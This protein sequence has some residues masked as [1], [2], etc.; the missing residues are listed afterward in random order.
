MGL[1][2]DYGLPGGERFFVMRMY[3]LTIYG[4]TV[5]EH[6]QRRGYDS[7]WTIVQEERKRGVEFGC[8]YSEA[9]IDGEL[10]S[11]P[12]AAL[13]E[14]GYADFKRAAEHDWPFLADEGVTTREPVAAVG[15]FRKDGTIDWKWDSLSGDR[16]G[17]LW[18]VDYRVRMTVQA[19][20]PHAAVQAGMEVLT[21]IPGTPAH[22][23]CAQLDVIGLT[24]PR[25]VQKVGT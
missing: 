11:N 8:W 9:C 20:D 19:A 23:A 5:D 3:E 14:I 4:H 1:N 7:D 22:P 2:P 10:G 13:V 12:I 25:F 24:H 18:I 6:L 17:D 21:S 16:T 15:E